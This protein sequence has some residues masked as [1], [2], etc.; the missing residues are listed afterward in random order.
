MGHFT[1]GRDG[2]NSQNLA[3]FF[4]ELRFLRLV[5]LNISFGFSQL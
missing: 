3:I 2:L 1:Q 4:A 5:D